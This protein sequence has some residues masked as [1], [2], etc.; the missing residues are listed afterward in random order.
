MLTVTERATELLTT[1]GGEYGAAT[2]T[3]PAAVASR[4]RGGCIGRVAHSC[5]LPSSHVAAGR[6]CWRGHVPS[7]AFGDVSRYRAGHHAWWWPQCGWIR[8]ASS[9]SLPCTRWMRRARG[10]F[11]RMLPS[12]RKDRR[13]VK[14]WARGKRCLQRCIEVLSR[15]PHVV[16]A[17]VRL[18]PTW[19]QLYPPMHAMSALGAWRIPHMLPSFRERGGA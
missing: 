18:K 10:A 8:P 12:S 16:V 11:Q 15:S 14:A 4:A 7:A 6:A 19:L 3:L 13:C 5:L 17:S 9:C 2:A 1:C